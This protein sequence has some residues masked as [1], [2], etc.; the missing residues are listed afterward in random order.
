ME[1]NWIPHSKYPLFY[2]LCLFLLHQNDLVNSRDIVA[3]LAKEKHKTLKLLEDTLN[4]NAQLQG[5]TGGVK[6]IK[7]NEVNPITALEKVCSVMTN[8]AVL[9]IDMADPL[10]GQLLRSFT[11]STGLPYITLLDRATLIEKDF[12]PDL[13][14]EIEPPGSVMMGVLRDVIIHESL[15]KIAVLYDNSFDLDKIPKR[16]LTGLPAQHLFQEIVSG[17]QNA[18]LKQLYRLEENQIRNFFIVANKENVKK[19]LE[20]DMSISC[21]GCKDNGRGTVILITGRPNNDVM[22]NEY[23]PFI[24]GLS[25]YIS[26]FTAEG[27][28]IDEAFMFDLMNLIK[29][30][31]LE[32]NVEKSVRLN[33][34]ECYSVI[35]PEPDVY[36]QSKAFVESFVNTSRDGVFGPLYFTN[37]VLKQRLTLSIKRLTFTSTESVHLTIGNWTEEKGLG[38]YEPSLLKPPGKKKYKIVVV[39]SYPPFVIPKGNK[40]FDGYCMDL[41]HEIQSILKFD[42]ELYPS[43]DGLV[44]SM[45]DKGHWNGIVKELMEK[46][47][48]IAIGPISV[49]AERENVIDFTV[50]YYDLVGLTILLKRPE[51]EYELFKFLVVLDE[52]VW[53][54][55]IASYFLFSGLLYVF[56]KLSPYSYQNNK[57]KFENVTP[58]PRVFTIK[59]GIWFCMMSLTPQGGGEAPRALSGRLIA[60]TWWL[61]GFIVIA[62]YTANLAA[63]LTV[64][65]LDEPIKSLDDLSS[66]QKVKYAPHNGSAAMVYFQRMAEIEQKFYS[67]WKNMSLDDTLDPV[68]RAKL[69]VWD[70]PV[71]N[72]YTKLWETMKRSGFPNSLGEALTSV[73]NGTFAYIGDA[74]ENQYQT[75][76]SMENCDLWQVGEEFSRKPFALAVQ[77]GSPLRNDLSTAILQ[78]LNQRTLEKLKKKW[79]DKNKV[80][81]PK[82][83]NESEGISLNNIGGVFILI[84]GGAALALVCLG[85]ELYFFKYKPK[86]AS[87]NYGVAKSHSKA[88][89]DNDARATKQNGVDKTWSDDRLESSS[90]ERRNG[91]VTNSELLLKRQTP[92]VSFSLGDSL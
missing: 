45:D 83:E 56:D 86:Q 48:D 11:R 71:S 31:L 49:M 5:W 61:F 78:L 74:A 77:N 7:L 58:E 41:L 8:G 91:S 1:N 76:K 13:H 64:S 23:I 29:T 55:I 25:K 82:L 12:D 80:K 17:T 15:T 66:Q 54:C 65:R 72:K 43:P 53:L 90:I 16:Y 34:S 39:P 60:A 57:H 50:P 59:E 63:F 37:N 75:I 36:N 51:F 88:N 70:Y 9:L 2:F 22:E 35:G 87:K 19:I 32:Q 26:T 69:A 3:V 33:E 10:T 14:L 81:C 18:T 92:G 52:D 20:T 27:S 24:R 44:G 73:K 84:A 68:E 38:L 42:Y 6:V 4:E 62:T 28:N 21:Q 67:I 40:S 89:L 79:W 46:R 47:A 30:Q 85:F